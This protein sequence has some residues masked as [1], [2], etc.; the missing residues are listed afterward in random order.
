METKKITID[1][2]RKKKGSFPLR[3]LSNW[4]IGDT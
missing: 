4:H 2:R 1:L 3:V